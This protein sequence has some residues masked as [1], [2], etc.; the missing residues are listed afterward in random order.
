MKTSKT[1]SLKTRPHIASAGSFVAI[2]DAFPSVPDGVR[3]AIKLEFKTVF[4]EEHRVQTVFSTDKLLIDIGAVDPSAL[5][6]KKI[7]RD[8]DLIKGIA[9]KHSKELGEMI[10]AMQSGG[11]KGINKAEKIAKKI[12]LTE[13]HASK[14]EGGFICVI[15]AIGLGLLLGGCGTT[16]SN[17][18]LKASTTPKPAK[19][20]GEWPGL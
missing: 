2:P 11:M 10:V 6:P 4:S 16:G 18:P 12:G 1:E 13:E 19:G 15:I 8:C 20:S 14:S 3:N 17:K 9:L 7:A 5:D